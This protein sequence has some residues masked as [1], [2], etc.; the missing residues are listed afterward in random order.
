[1][2][3]HHMCWRICREAYMILSQ[4]ADHN[5][6]FGSVI[7]LR[8]SRFRGIPGYGSNVVGG[9]GGFCSSLRSFWTHPW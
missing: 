8:F 9:F 1:M 5:I 7:L 3:V 6:K 4:R 2:V